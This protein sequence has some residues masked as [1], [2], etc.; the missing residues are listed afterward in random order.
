MSGLFRELF[1]IRYSSINLKISIVG[2]IACLLS[3]FMC[4]G[5]H[6]E[7]PFWAAPAVI[8]IISPNLNVILYKAPRRLLATFIGSL[9]AIFIVLT[10]SD[11]PFLTLTIL[12][13]LGAVVLYLSKTTAEN[14]FSLFLAVHILFL[15]IALIFEPAIGYS[16]A[17]NRF[18][19]NAI[20]VAIT[21]V[22][23]SFIYKLPKGAQVSPR[24]SSSN[25]GVLYTSTLIV[26]I[27]LA[28]ITWEIFKVP[29]SSLNM[30][31]SIIT[32]VG[33]NDSSSLLKGKQRLFGCIIGICTAL[34]TIGLSSVSMLLFYIS[35]F[36]FF[37]IF[38]YYNLSHEKHTYGGIQAAM[39]FVVMCFPSASMEISVS[40]GLYRALGIFLGVII[41]SSVFKTFK[42]VFDQ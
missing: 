42:Y 8:A 1:Y 12:L 30:I 18:I 15:G 41:L 27:V 31:I 38:L 7:N 17:E 3:I 23:F 6:V 28:V 34:I 10:F 9:I 14:Y 19:A 16:V 40:G 39:G 26:S 13:C 35:C 24:K 5:L 37:T 20:G 36:C 32:I 4:L 2:A 25:E 11:Y 22:V 29:G 21:C 33:I